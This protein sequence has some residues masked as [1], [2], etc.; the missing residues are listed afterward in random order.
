VSLSPEV[1]CALLV[2]GGYLCGSVPFGLLIARAR[3]VDVRAV[4]SGNIGATNVARAL[5]KTTGVIVLVLDAAKGYGPTLAALL[6]RPDDP[7]VAAGTA[8]AAILG[9]V[10]PIWLKLHGGKGVATALG[11]FLALA[12][13]ATAI[14][15]AAFLVIYA[16][17]RI[18]SLSSLAGATAMPI[19]MLVRG[20]PWPFVAL[21]TIAWLLI[22]VR[23]RGNLRRLLRREEAKL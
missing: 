6:L 5:G 12:P 7:R 14:A 1:L 8:L 18:V 10:F 13:V 15:A 3:G 16:A 4:G 23:H 17:S 2:A 19:I 21:A 11:T 9:H 20:A 22:V